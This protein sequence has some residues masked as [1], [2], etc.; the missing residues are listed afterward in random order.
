K[1]HRANSDA[2][3]ERIWKARS[4]GL[5]LTLRPVDDR[6]EAGE[7]ICQRWRMV[8]APPDQ[9]GL[10]RWQSRRQGAKHQSGPFD[11]GEGGGGR[12]H[13]ESGRYK[14]QLGVNVVDVLRRPWPRARLG[15]SGQ[16]SVVIT[17]LQ[18]AVQHHQ[19]LAVKVAPGELPL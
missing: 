1:I 9:H 2:R 5:R 10:H 6:L 19:T 11:L 3:G 7:E 15:A 13:A 4:L 16:E 8:V 14:P 17:V 12:R 18:I